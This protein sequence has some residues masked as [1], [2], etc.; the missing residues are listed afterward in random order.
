M[1]GNAEDGNVF[2]CHLRV[3]ILWFKDGLLTKR[4]SHARLIVE[5][6]DG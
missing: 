2:H 3:R 1:I 5:F 6:M 4:L